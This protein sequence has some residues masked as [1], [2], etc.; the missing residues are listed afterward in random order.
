MFE[1]FIFIIHPSPKGSVFT[2]SGWS[3][4]EGFTSITSPAIGKN[5]SETVLTASTEP[6]IS[7]FAKDCPTVSIST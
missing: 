3:F 4:R 2:N 7:S 1:T 6:K 5:K